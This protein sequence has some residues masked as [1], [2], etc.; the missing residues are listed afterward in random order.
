MRASAPGL[1]PKRVPS[2]GDTIDGKF[3]PGGTSIEIYTAS[4]FSSTTYFGSDAGIFRPERF[5]EADEQDRTEMERLVELG[6][7][8]GR[9]QCPGKPVALMELNKVYFEVRVCII[10]EH[11]TLTKVV[12]Q[13]LRAF[14]F[15]VASPTSPWKSRSYSV[16]VEQ[17]M[18][19]KVS[20]AA[21]IDWGTWIKTEPLGPVVSVRYSICFTALPR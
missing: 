5:T 15:Q 10:R 6:F 2:E 16:F 1:Y 17:D 18:W 12:A 8:Y 13:L 19:V 3:I 7:G 9:F 11:V 20:E 4:L 21:K 14:D